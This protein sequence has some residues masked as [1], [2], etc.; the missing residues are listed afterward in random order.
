MYTKAKK[1]LISLLIFQMTTLGYTKT[2]TNKDNVSIDHFALPSDVKGMVKSP[3]SVFYSSS[4]KGRVLMPV[5]MWGNFSK[6]GLHF[7][8]VDTNLISGLSM[9]GGPSRYAK[10][11]SVTLTR[12]VD[13]EAKIYNFDLKSG[14]NLEAHN[15]TLKPGDTI[16][17]ERE[18]KIEDRSFYLSLASFIFSVFSAYIIYDRV[19]DN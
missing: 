8:P 2:P 17:I 12:R 3:G 1:L 19:K 6:S 5:N 14:G 16:F 11:D 15:F 7:V 4:I 18:T 13:N 9:A 10:L